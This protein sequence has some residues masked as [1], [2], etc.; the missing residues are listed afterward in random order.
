[1]SNLAQYWQGP[2][3]D[4]LLGAEEAAW[5]RSIEYGQLENYVRLNFPN[6]RVHD[7]RTK[8]YKWWKWHEPRA[9]SKWL[10]TYKPVKT[11][12]SGKFVTIHW[13]K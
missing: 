7:R 13:N 4:T 6:R 12:K 9:R 10:K 8:A 5:Q 11:D 2:V 1:M 3:M